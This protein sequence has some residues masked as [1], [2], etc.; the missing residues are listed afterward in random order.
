MWSK[1]PR[2]SLEQ[3]V[4]AAHPMKDA[5]DHDAVL[6]GREENEIAAVDG[7]PQTSSEILPSPVSARP[8]TDAGRR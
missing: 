1:G 2:V 4:E 8:N 6:A 7:L 5:L 3:I